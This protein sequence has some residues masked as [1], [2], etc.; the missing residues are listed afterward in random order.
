MWGRRVLSRRG[1]NSDL[2]RSWHPAKWVAVLGLAIQLAGCADSLGTRLETARD[3]ARPAGLS[4][5]WVKGG[6]F[7]LATFT[8]LTDP[9]QPVTVYIEGDG[10][11]WITRTQVSSDP[12]PRTPTGLKLAALDPGPNVVYLARPCQYKGVGT[13]LHCKPPIWSDARFSESVI[14]ATS[15]VIDETAAKER[16]P[17]HLVGY[18]GGAAVALLVAARR[19]DIVSIRTVAGNVDNRAVIALHRVS[20]MPA[21]LDPADVASSL[22]GIPQI[23]YVG[24]EDGIVPPAIAE[25]YARKAGP[26]RC[27]AIHMVPGLT[28]ATG[29]TEVWP[30]VVR[31][32]PGCGERS[33]SY[34]SLEST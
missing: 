25:S 21:S 6:D 1:S 4:L 22:A 7:T 26:R 17:L 29:W 19:T 15:K 28:H 30:R 5:S 33:V 32:M 24:E 20:P 10:L 8:R 23:H 31:D 13:N 9:N 12:T 34:G 27:I 3:I 14:A 2:N 18:S 16:K 11:A